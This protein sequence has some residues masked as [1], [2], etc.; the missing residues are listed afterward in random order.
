MTDRH[1]TEQEWKRFSKGR[2]LKDGPLVKALAALEKA[3]AP[4]ARLEALD[5]ID[6]QSDLLRKAGKDDRELVDYLKGVDAAAARAR[7][8]EEAEAKRSAEADDD[9]AESP[10]LLTA[11]MIPLA[12]AVR[13]GETMQALVAV[14]GA[15]AA[16]LLARRAIAPSRRKLLA[17]YLDAGGTV[18]YIAGE[19]MFEDEAFT[20]VV[21]AAAAGLAKKLTAA[22]YRQTDLCLRV[23]VRGEDPADVDEDGEDAE[24]GAG[25]AGTAAGS[26]AGADGDAAQQA[27]RRFDAEFAA[28][29]PLMLAALKAQSA[30][31]S[32]IRA[33]AEFAR[34]KAQAGESAAAEAALAQLRKLVAPATPP[35]AEAGIGKVDYAKCRLA[36]EG[37]KRKVEA[38]LDKLERAILEDF[39]DADGFDEIADK[40]G[41]LDE[42]L[43]GFAGDL[44]DTLDRALNAT[45]AAERRRHHQ[46][47][48]AQIR[49]FQDYAANDPFIARLEANP[50]VPIAARATLVGT[51]GVLA[52]LIA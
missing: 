46:E 29:A 11:K 8:S 3:S 50:F 47:A 7:K 43:A 12:R 35:A 34:G 27:R 31:A 2:A 33:V 51:L 40:L 38:E 42:V 9:E 18:K 44:S 39:R 17:D 37:A 5:E 15:E 14:A 19:C 49:R 28:L 24:D 45:D 22:L 10:A 48:A 30:E 1:L 25:R 26:A 13:K 23:R 32:K 36:W 6:K 41:K 20:F 21:Q 52:K 16:V 4:A